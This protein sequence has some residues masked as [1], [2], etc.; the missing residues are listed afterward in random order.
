[1]AKIAVLGAGPMGL[2]TAYQL[3]KEGHQPIIFEASD[4]IGGMTASF[5]FGGLNIE[6]YYHFHCL[7]D[8]AYFEILSELNILDKMNWTETKMGFWFLGVVQPWGNPIALLK[9]KGLD[10]FSKIRYGVHIF[11][12][13]KR[14]NWQSLDSKEATHW[15]KKWIG[16]K[17]YDVLWKTLFEYKFYNFSNN[18]SSAWIWSRIRRIGRSRYSIFREKLGYLEGGSET[19]LQ[20]MKVYIE[21]NG[22][23]FKL[24]SIISKVEIIESTVKGIHIG[25]SFESFDRVI[26]TIPLTYIPKIMPDLPEDLLHK[27]S[28]VNNIAVVCVI[29]K[30][31]KSLTENFWLNINDPNMDI[32]GL[33]EYTNLRPL[34]DHIVY[35]PFYMPGEHKKFSEPNQVFLDKVKK[36]FKIIN[37][38]LK[39]EDF[40]EMHASRY[41]YAQ[42]ICPPNFLDYL[43]D[44]DLPID[45]L[46]V[47]DTSHYYPEDRGISDSIKLGRKL[48]IMSLKDI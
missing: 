29:V 15:I 18:L 30:L 43:P 12:S 13:T 46:I 8:K 10:L 2:A 31:K 44:A 41:R 25:D 14:N 48:A 32:P 9:F 27:F 16:V 3:V 45:G 7:S 28:T 23:V 22:G 37:S 20:A 19:L 47:A 17:A 33:V 6:R 11:I 34:S 35:V 24:N 40:L 39:D 5:D 21:D 1:M 42:P 38:E 26:S 4:R 36:Y